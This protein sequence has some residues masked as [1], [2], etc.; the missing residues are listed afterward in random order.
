MLIFHHHRCSSNQLLEKASDF[1]DNAL[2]VQ[3]LCSV[4]RLPKI[5]GL[6]TPGN[7]SE[8]LPELRLVSMSYELGG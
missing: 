8:D 4:D 2:R 7:D 5:C 1:P 6:Y 3:E